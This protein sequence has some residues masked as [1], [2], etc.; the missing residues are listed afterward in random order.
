MKIKDSSNIVVLTTP[1]PNNEGY[2]C[3]DLRKAIPVRH[4]KQMHA[5]VKNAALDVPITAESRL[6][7]PMLSAIE[8]D[9]KRR[10]LVEFEEEVDSVV[11]VAPGWDSILWKEDGARWGE[12]AECVD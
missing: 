3:L 11:G 12:T 4:S 7:L 9:A 8:L 1:S 2:I 6:S 5:Q 10:S